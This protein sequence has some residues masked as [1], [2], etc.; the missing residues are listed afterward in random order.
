MVTN[1]NNMLDAGQIKYVP[2][3]NMKPKYIREFENKLA[4]ARKIQDRYEWAFKE[5]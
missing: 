5:G 4:E 2:D 1:K 3:V